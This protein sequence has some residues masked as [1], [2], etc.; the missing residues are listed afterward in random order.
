MHRDKRELIIVTWSSG[1]RPVNIRARA[2]AGV[3]LGFFRSFARNKTQN[4][5]RLSSFVR[6]DHVRTWSLAKFWAVDRQIDTPMFDTIRTWHRRH[7]A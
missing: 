3:A 4:V 5:R 1:T 2:G 6:V 7:R